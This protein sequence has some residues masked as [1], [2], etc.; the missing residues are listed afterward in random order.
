MRA[1]AFVRYFW[2]AAVQLTTTVSGA[3]VALRPR[4]D[5]ESLAILGHGV[6]LVAGEPRRAG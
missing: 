4:V 1:L 6:H 5:Q 2:I 3:A